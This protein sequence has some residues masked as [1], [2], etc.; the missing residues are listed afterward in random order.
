MFNHNVQLIQAASG[1]QESKMQ[2]TLSSAHTLSSLNREWITKV[3]ESERFKK[4]GQPTW[5]KVIEVQ[6]TTLDKLITRYGIPDYIKIDVEGFEKNVLA[7]LNERVKCVSFEFTLPELKDDAIACINK[8]D[9]LGK[10]EYISLNDPS[11]TKRVTRD[12]IIQEIEKISTAGELS[13]GDIF[14][15]LTN[16]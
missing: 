6:V 8:L 4:H 12:G 2:M 10:Y 14:A 1:E 13:N 7:G 11:G 5:N 15:H 9:S 16:G 3:N